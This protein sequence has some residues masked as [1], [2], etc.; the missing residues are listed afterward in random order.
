MVVAQSRA[1]PPLSFQYIPL[2]VLYGVFLY[3]GVASLNGIQVRTLRSLGPQFTD[4]ET[5][6]QNSK[7]RSR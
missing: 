5:E 1:L 6:V 7:P 4:E 3:M 2:P